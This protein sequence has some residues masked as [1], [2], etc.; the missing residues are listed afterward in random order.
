MCLKVKPLGDLLETAEEL[1]L[2]QFREHVA[3]NNM[4]HMLRHDGAF[5]V[6]APSDLAFR[7]ATPYE[8]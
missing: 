5:T 3:R 2:R 7:D 4:T 6:F 8:W 1:E